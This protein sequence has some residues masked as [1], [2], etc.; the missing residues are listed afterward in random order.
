[1]RTRATLKPVL[2]G[3]AVAAIAVAAAACG[4]SNDSS[5]NG[6]NGGG[7]TG[8]TSVKIGFMGDL[9]GANAGIVTPPFNAAT[10]AVAQYN[11][12][13]PKV[14]VDLV[15]YDSQGKPEQAVP[16]AQTAIKTD[17][18]VA[19]I[20]PAF[21]G[22]SKNVGP[23]LEEGKIPSISP[24]ATNVDLAKNGWQYWHR[25]VANDGVQGPGIADFVVRV[26]KP[27][28]AFVVDDK[29]TY[30]QGL[31]Q[32]VTSALKGANVTPGTD[33]IDAD[34]SD[35]GTTVNKVKAANPDVIFFGG[36]YSAAG[37]LLKQLREGGVTT[38]KFLT[39]DGSLDPGLVSGAGPANAEGALVGCPCKIPDP[40]GNSD[41][42]V[43]KFVDDYKAK[44]NADP[45][46]Y[47]LEGYD[48]ANAFLEAIKANNTTSDGINNYLKTI[49]YQG[50]SKEIKFQSNGEPT[51]NQIFIYQVKAGKITLL[52]D[53]KQ[54]TIG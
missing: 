25:D 38:A 3:A 31:A 22:E 36:Y 14:H 34:G 53:S 17:K 11:A 45:A 6:G 30:G 5:G 35:F 7:T 40:T 51:V 1:V 20:G 44:F 41:P 52:G 49:D 46:I 24:S 50:L 48:A 10:L 54:V 19:M 43:Q 4:N 15:K 37:K 47:A 13:N 29:S 26:L 42:K 9:S 21:S 12:T 16:L 8:A 18:V 2:V 28:S 39:G 23:V 33:S 27:K 32:N